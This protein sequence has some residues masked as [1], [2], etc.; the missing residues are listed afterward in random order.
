MPDRPRHRSAETLYVFPNGTKLKGNEIT[1]WKA[2]PA[3]T[4]V[5]LSDMQSDNEAEGI[6]MIGTNGDSAADIAGD[7][8]RART[9]VY[10]L[11]DSRVKQ[12]HE[13][14]EA[15]VKSLPEKTRVLVGYVHGGYVTAKRSAFYICGEKW[16]SDSTFYRFKD[17]RIVA[18][19]EMREGAIPPLTMVFFQQ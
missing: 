13:L 3:G 1:N 10:F 9:T 16:D 8:I 4:K 17:G 7:E 5:V 15:E 18:G 12:G 6:S 14:S 19:A 2:M 11:P